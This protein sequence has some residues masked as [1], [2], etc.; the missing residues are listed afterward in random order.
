MKQ[1]IIRALY[2]KYE[3]EIEDA[4]TKIELMMKRTVIIPEHIDTET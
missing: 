2:K 1:A 4:H 3:A